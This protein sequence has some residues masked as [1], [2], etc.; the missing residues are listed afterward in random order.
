MEWLSLNMLGLFILLLFLASTAV[1]LMQIQNYLY[2]IVLRLPNWP[3][4]VRVCRNVKVP[5]SDGAIL[6]ADIYKPKAKGTFPAILIRTPYSKSNVSHNY[7]LIATI[8]ACQGY[9]VV[10]QDV[11][12]KYESE[13]RFEPFINEE[14]DGK[15]TICWITK[16]S[17]SNGVVAVWGFSYLGSCA[18][19]TAAEA[20]EALKTLVTLFC[21]HDAYS[22]WVDKGVPYLKDILFWLSKHHGRH[23]RLVTH[24]E[25]DKIILQ[26]PVLQFDKRLKDG[27]ATFKTWMSHLQKDA[28]WDSFS[29]SNRRE[30]IKVPALFIGG[31]YD[32]FLNNTIHDFNETIKASKGTLSSKSRLIIGPWSH[33]P[34]RTFPNIHFGKQ[35]KFRK[36]FR[37]MLLWL[38][39][40]V[41]GNKRNFDNELPVHFFVMGKNK[42]CQAK[43]WPPPGGEEES[44]YLTSNGDA[45]G[46]KSRG[47]LILK[48][49][50]EIAQDSYIYNPEDPVPSIGNRMLYG[51][52]SEGPREQKELL[53]RD[54]L[55]I[56]T[57]EPFADDYTILGPVT[58]I[59]YVSS[60]ALDTDFFAKL[61]DRHPNGRSFFLLSGLIR[62]RFLDSVKATHGIEQSRVYRI[63][64]PIG[65][66]AHTFLPGHSLELQV[67]SSDF[68]DHERNLNTGGSNEGDVKEVIARQTIYHGGIY[69]S[70]IAC[71]NYRRIFL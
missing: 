38:D 35:A 21:C 20:P 58:V 14:K 55:L 27:I 66:T 37:T 4:R 69:P 60:S 8:L 13:G 45:N 2:V 10:I 16:E 17:W 48:Q 24:E 46:A 26:L 43:S 5:M 3:W 50:Q 64:I 39:C 31:W 1:W 7:P 52:N 53:K 12:G 34:M 67:T 63:E 65:E 41:K 36:L 6:F 61:S 25:V 29:V 30:A 44:F 32:R 33:E 62:M 51:N 42:W 56:Y 47:K 68:P 49:K 54:D 28:Y 22:G 71:F 40:W 18:W 11:R 15:E 19:L 23:G 57:S 9:A 59:L 70:H